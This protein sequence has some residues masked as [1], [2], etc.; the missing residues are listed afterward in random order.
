MLGDR[1]WLGKLHGELCALIAPVFA[2]ARSRFAA[3]VYVAALL[4]VTG[5][6]KSCW[7]LGEEAGHATPRRMQA[8]LAI[9]D[10]LFQRKYSVRPL[11]SWACER[12]FGWR[13][14]LLTVP[15]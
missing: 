13:G 6:R 11:R 12:G 3:F 9:D 4:A 1:A 5:D 8:L 14:R 7:Q 10:T 2:Q 15:G